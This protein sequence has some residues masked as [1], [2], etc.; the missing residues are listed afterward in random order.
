MD[1]RHTFLFDVH[2]RKFASMTSEI[3]A[4]LILVVAI[5]AHLICQQE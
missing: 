4:C 1:D 3:S 2:G 5:R